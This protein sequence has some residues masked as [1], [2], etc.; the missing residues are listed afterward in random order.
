MTAAPVFG[1][2]MKTAR[3]TTEEKDS[4]SRSLA[5][6]SFSYASSSREMVFVAM[7]EAVRER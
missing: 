3:R 5:D 2:A 7:H 1:V 4:R 6:L